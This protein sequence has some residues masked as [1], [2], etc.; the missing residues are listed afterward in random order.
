[1]TV[2][3]RV[4]RAFVPIAG[5][6]AALA[7]TVVFVVGGTGWVLW[8][9]VLI[10]LGILLCLVDVALVAGGTE[11]PSGASPDTKERQ[12]IVYMGVLLMLMIVQLVQSDGATTQVGGMSGRVSSIL[13]N[14][15][16]RVAAGVLVYCLVVIAWMLLRMIGR[17]LG[18]QRNGKF[19]IE[20]T[21][22]TFRSSLLRRYPISTDAMQFATTL[23]RDPK[24]DNQSG[25]IIRWGA[26]ALLGQSGARISL[27]GEP[28][29]LIF[30]EPPRGRRSEEWGRRRFRAIYGGCDLELRTRELFGCKIEFHRVDGGAAGYIEKG[31]L[32]A[33]RLFLGG[34][35]VARWGRAS[36]WGNRRI[37]RSTRAPGWALEFR[38]D[39][40][41]PGSGTLQALSGNVAD[42]P[43]EM[44]LCTVF[45]LGMIRRW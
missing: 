14:Q 42:E 23:L 31:L 45:L 37:L 21:R 12:G 4:A 27:D 29:I 44:Y 22:G 39:R 8:A 36:V 25:R 7:G 17:R 18:N 5:A 43:I 28:A 34:K 41:R 26:E 15:E 20:P 38:P 1:M 2:E 9:G 35:P 24:S 19:S 30:Q 6:L 13:H 33:G 40:G 32:G 11:W 10:T 16:L 3:V